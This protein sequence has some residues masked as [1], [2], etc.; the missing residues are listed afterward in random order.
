MGNLYTLWKNTMK[1]QLTYLVII[2]T[3]L[4]WFHMEVWT[5][6]WRICLNT[7]NCWHYMPAISISITHSQTQNNCA[8]KE[9]KPLGE[10][11]LS[12]CIN[13]FVIMTSCLIL[14]IFQLTCGQGSRVVKQ[15]LGRC[16]LAG[17]PTGPNGPISKDGT[18]RCDIEDCTL[19]HYR[20]K[21]TQ[22][23][24]CPTY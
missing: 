12:L 19:S 15:L 2:M 4:S 23:H 3:N 11:E 1:T 16:V 20:Q 9:W 18:N 10:C 17:K 22:V 24:T 8:S 7:R 6:I 14:P 13:V 5:H 21:Y